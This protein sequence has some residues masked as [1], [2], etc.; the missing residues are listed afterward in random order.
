MQ[1]KNNNNYTEDVNKI[2]KVDQIHGHSILHPR[3]TA[4]I[5]Y[6]FQVHLCWP[7]H[8]TWL[9]A[10]LENKAPQMLSDWNYVKLIIWHKIIQ[11]IIF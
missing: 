6:I 5:L 4:Y 10:W 2:D 3:N 7:S 1:T 11:K 9:Y 8:Q